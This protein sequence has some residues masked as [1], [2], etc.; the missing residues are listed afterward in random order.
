MIVGNKVD[1]EDMRMVSSAEGQE[2]AK[3]LGAGFIETSAKTSLNV[4]EAFFE[5]IRMTPR[6]NGKDYKVAV[7][8]SGG[9]GKSS[10]NLMLSNATP[11]CG[12]Q[13]PSDCTALIAVLSQYFPFALLYCLHCQSSSSFRLFS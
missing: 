4:E 8:G 13:N 2:L 12:S 1:C 6:T 5:L 10:P 11:F 3:R 9:V 7:V